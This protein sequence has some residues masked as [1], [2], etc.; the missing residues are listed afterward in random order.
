ME[1]ICT[2]HDLVELRAYY[3][4]KEEFKGKCP[5]GQQTSEEWYEHVRENP[6]L[7][8]LDESG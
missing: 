8:G 4:L 5:V 3:Q 2:Q 7:Y 1:Q 6:G